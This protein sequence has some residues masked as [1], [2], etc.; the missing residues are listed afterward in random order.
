MTGS[1]EALT[2][3]TDVDCTGQQALVT[4]S[5]S[6]IGREAALALGRLGADVVVHGRDTAVGEAVVDELT[7]IGADGTFVPADF[8]SVDEVRSLAETVRTDTDGLDILV[9]NAGGLFREGRLTDLGVERTFH[10]NH[11][12]PFLLTAALLDHLRDGARVVTTASAAHRGTALDTARVKSVE[13]YSAFWAYSHSKLANVLFATELAHL[14]DV[15][16]RPITSNSVHPGAIPGSGFSRFLPG[17][18][19][20]LVRGLSAVP[21]VTTV[22][23]GAAEL[24][25]PAVSP[26]TADISGRYFADQQPTNPSSEARDADAA[27]RLWE[28]S[29]EVL[30]IDTPL[31]PPEL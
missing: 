26:R 29:A 22:A 15:S 12:S 28:F 3:V 14:L 5:T 18:V 2:G 17:P 16:D 9:N 19:P 20:Q 6:G 25:F 21:G 4:G 24:L 10:V 8:E 11:L 23:D 7:E 1:P 27:R 30:D 31:E 13:R